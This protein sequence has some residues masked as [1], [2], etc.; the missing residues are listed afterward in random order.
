[1][2]SVA[3][4]RQA[5]Y[6]A[7]W[8]GKAWNAYKADPSLQRPEKN[9]ALEELKGYPGSGRLVIA[10]GIN[11]L[12]SLRADRFAREFNLRLALLGSGLEYRRLEEL[13]RTGR[14]V[15]LPLKFPMPPNV[16]TAEVAMLSLIH[17]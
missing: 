10:D 17:I 8:Y 14:T 16:G 3:L 13:R 11:E 9:T 2:G 15:I 1:M 4:A 6:D 7:S 12:Y 5:F